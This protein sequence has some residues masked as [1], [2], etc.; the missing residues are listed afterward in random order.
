MI[1]EVDV[2]ATFQHPC[3]VLIA[4]PTGSGKTKAIV[5][6]IEQRNQLFFPVPNNILYCYTMWQPDFTYLKNNFQMIKFHSGIPNLEDLN[7]ENNNLIILDDLMRE[8]GKDDQVLDLFTK[9]SHHKNTSVMFLTQN[10]FSKGKNSRTISLNAQYIMM[11]NNPR[12]KTQ[13]SYLA[14][15]MFPKNPKLLEAA[16]NDA[17]KGAHGYLFIDLKQSTPHKLRIQTNIFSEN[18]TIYC[19]E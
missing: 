1:E 3:T 9:G 18:R 8:G 14:R 10:L 2:P 6:I 19:C 4:G 5:K 16:Y 15:Q 11:F 17:T 12:D 13:I 7:A